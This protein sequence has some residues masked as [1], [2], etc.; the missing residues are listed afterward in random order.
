MPL[1]VA[2]IVLW[3]GGGTQIVI[4]G[5][6]GAEDTIALERAVAAHDL[7]WAVKIP[8]DPTATAASPLPWLRAMT[9]RD[10]RA[11]AY[12]CSDFT[13]QAPVTDASAL[14][15]QIDDLV[16]GKRVG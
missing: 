9:L 11:A 4:A 7:P 13:C 10:G 15:A 16:R 1:M 8:V 14:D 2:N 3:H 5:R 6:P 12:V